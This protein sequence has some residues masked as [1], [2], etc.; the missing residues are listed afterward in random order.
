MSDPN[1][2]YSSPL[3]SFEGYQSDEV[4]EPN[5]IHEQVSAIIDSINNEDLPSPDLNNAE[6]WTF[7]SEDR[8]QTL[9][10][11][12]ID[13]AQR[14]QRHLSLATVYSGAGEDQRVDPDTFIEPVV[15]GVSRLNN[16]VPTSATSSVSSTESFLSGQ[17]DLGRPKSA[18]S[19]ATVKMARNPTAAQ[20]K[21][22]TLYHKCVMKYEDQYEGLTPSMVPN[23]QLDYYVEK[24]RE[25]TEEFSSIILLFQCEPCDEIYTE[26]MS[27]KAKDCKR[28][29]VKFF[30]FLEPVKTG[31]SNRKTGPKNILFPRGN[32]CIS[33]LPEIKVYKT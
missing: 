31:Q 6:F 3:E 22:V 15:P 20:K 23:S 11:T 9:D 4:R 32:N 26:E 33:L 8:R 13:S 14:N 17:S 1:S 30:Y 28:N 25:L 16:Q 18:A 5:S 29:V 24:S 2:G 7:N 27:T 10:S 19:I 12:H 21:M